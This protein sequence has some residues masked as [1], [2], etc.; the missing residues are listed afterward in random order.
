M[1]IVEVYQAVDFTSIDSPISTSV[2]ILLLY[3]Y[4][5]KEIKDLIM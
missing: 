2:N 1:N 4:N 3:G 5:E